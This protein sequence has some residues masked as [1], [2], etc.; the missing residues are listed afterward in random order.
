MTHALSGSAISTGLTNGNC[1]CSAAAFPRRS[2][3]ARPSQKAPPA[4][5]CSSPSKARLGVN[6]VY[7]AV[8]V[9]RVPN[10]VATDPAWTAPPAFTAT[11]AD[12]KPN[13]ATWHDAHDWLRSS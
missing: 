6:D 11:F 5:A 7:A 10:R 8:G 1:A 3:V 4:Y 2:P 9:R 13:S 12:E